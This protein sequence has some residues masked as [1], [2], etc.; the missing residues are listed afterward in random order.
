MSKNHLTANSTRASHGLV[1]VARAGAL[2]L[3][4][5][6]VACNDGGNGG[7]IGIDPT[8]TPV[9]AFPVG[10]SPAAATS[11]S[12]ALALEQYDRDAKATAV[13]SRSSRFTLIPEGANP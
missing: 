5:L 2:L 10:L 6:L 1:P 3:A 11:N 12:G 13:F 9:P 7:G 4:A 8:P